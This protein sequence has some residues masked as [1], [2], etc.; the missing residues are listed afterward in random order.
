MTYSTT[1]P[2]RTHAASRRALAPG[3]LEPKTPVPATQAPDGN[4][5]SDMSLIPYPAA[6]E[7]R[8]ATDDR[9]F[10]GP[11]G[12]AGKALSGGGPSVADTNA[13]LDGLSGSVLSDV[14]AIGS[15]PLVC[16]ASEQGGLP[17]ADRESRR[18]S[19]P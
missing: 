15:E 7:A 13:P 12:S 16:G 14:D 8:A 18:T 4:P 10:S 3:N 19:S 11:A 17:V 1:I 2:T 5:V 6:K 9:D